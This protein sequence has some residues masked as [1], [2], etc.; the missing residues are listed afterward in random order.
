MSKALNRRWLRRW[1]FSGARCLKAVSV[2]RKRAQ[3]VKTS[4]EIRLKQLD[5][6]I[7]TRKAEAR[8]MVDLQ[9]KVKAHRE[10]KELEKQ[11]S[12]MRLSLYQAQD[13]VDAKK[14]GLL[15]E[16]EARLSQSLSRE[17]LFTI[18][19]RLA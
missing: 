18:R 10:I 17:V 9:E 11:R 4:L 7:K 2:T 6:E 3:D 15:E 1:L 19:W 12:E 14:E 5:V 16:I 8:K 13:D